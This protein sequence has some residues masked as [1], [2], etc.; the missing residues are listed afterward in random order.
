M[1]SR[2]V[3][4]DTD[5][6]IPRA[7][8]H[9]DY[10]A[11]SAQERARWVEALPA[12]MN[13]ESLP[14]EGDPH[15]EVKWSAL[16]ALRRFYEHMQRQVYVGADLTVYYPNQPRF[17]ADL[18]VT[19]D[20]DAHSRDKWLVSAEGKGLD[21]VLEVFIS[22]ERRKDVFDSVRFYA[23]LG[24]GE[25]FVYDRGRQLL[26]AYRLPSPDAKSYVPIVPR[27]GAY[28]STLLGLDLVIESGQLR[29]Y[30]GNAPLLDAGELITKL[31]HL[32]DE[33]ARRADE[34]TRRT[35]ELER[36][37]TELERQS[38]R[39][40]GLERRIAELEDELDRR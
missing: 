8:S 4:P 3:V 19:L 5:G 37:I 14:N 25:C 13:A 10:T 28:P 26:S 16:E 24:I 7:P 30:A 36:R 34:E 2:L 12:W 29:F 11:M 31:E 39:A 1:A 9:L 6:K 38:V 40:E 22:G 17:A 35:E 21:V 15:R 32:S 18:L 20:V 23:E 33:S 27:R